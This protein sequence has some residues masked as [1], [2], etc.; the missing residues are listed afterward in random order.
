[1]A[2]KRTTHKLRGVMLL[3]PSGSRKGLLTSLTR[4]AITNSPMPRD[5]LPL[6]DDFDNMYEHDKLRALARAGVRHV[7]RY[8]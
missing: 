8:S 4:Y 6:P 3:P 1:M 2:K 7:P 5:M